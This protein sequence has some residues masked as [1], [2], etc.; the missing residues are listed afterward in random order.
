ML[1]I[2]HEDKVNCA[3]DACM[4]EDCAAII[5]AAPQ[6]TWTREKLEWIR[7]VRQK[8]LNWTLPAGHC[9]LCGGTALSAWTLS[10]HSFVANH[11]PAQVDDILYTSL[12]IADGSGWFATYREFSKLGKEALKKWMLR[13][14]NASN[15]IKV[16][17]KLS[18]PCGYN[19]H[20]TTEATGIAVRKIQ[21]WTEIRIGLRFPEVSHGQ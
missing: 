12:L 17:E 10:E 7:V 1:E 16:Y 11:N 5:A 3:C 2:Q 19:M 21:D 20:E 14:V 18:P 9:A 13:M 6:S 15:L 4:A 8:P